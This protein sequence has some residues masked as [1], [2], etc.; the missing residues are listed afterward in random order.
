MKNRLLA[1]CVLFITLAGSLSAKSN[2]LKEPKK[3]EVILVGKISF[4]TDQDKNFLYESREVPENYRKNYKNLITMPFCSPKYKV[5]EEGQNPFLFTIK[6]SEMQK[7][8]AQAWV[9]DGEYFFVKYELNKERTVYLDTA[10]L[11]V[12]ASYLLPVRLPLEM[13]ITVPEGEKFLYIGDYE[14]KATGFAFELTRKVKDNFDEAQAALDN[15]TEVKYSLCR[16]NPEFL[17]ERFFEKVWYQTEHFEFN[18]ANWYKEIKDYLV[19]N[20][21]E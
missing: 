19:E 21:Q 4:S 11:F 2:F 14:F 1:F 5:V 20:E 8:Q 17:D 7:F 13:K 16:A 10:L 15:K 6:S 9:L 3:N 12:N 18:I